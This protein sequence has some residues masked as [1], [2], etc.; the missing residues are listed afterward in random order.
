MS[1]AWLTEG[2][3]IC[4]SWCA[5]HHSTTEMYE[6]RVHQGVMAAVTLTAEELEHGEESGVSLPGAEG[7]PHV[8]LCL[9][10]HYREEW[11]R[12]WVGRDDTPH[13]F[14]LTLGEAEWL[15]TELRNLVGDEEESRRTLPEREER[16]ERE[17]DAARAE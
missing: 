14:H 15:A 13:G 17:R 12:I 6:D 8:N 5:Q 7:L 2:F 1:A 3:H 4:P 9:V 10:Q 11:P 16:A